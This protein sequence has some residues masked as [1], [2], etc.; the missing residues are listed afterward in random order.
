MVNSQ[1]D[2]ISVTVLFVVNL[3]NYVDRYTVAGV[4]TAVQT[5]Y[6]IS[7]SLG[8]LIQT[9]FLISFMV[10]SPICGYLGDRFNRKWIM[11]IGVGIWLGAVLG[12]SFVPANHFWLFL[13]L[14]SFVGIGEAS[15]SNVAPSL[16]SDMFNG[17]KRSTVFMIFYFAIPVGSGL[18]FIVGSNVATL[19][20][21]WQWGIRVSAIAGFIVMIALVLFTYE[22]ERGAADRANGDAKDTVVTTNTTYLE[23]LVILLKT[24][25]LVACTWGYT[26]LV[27]V[28]GTLSWWEPTVIQHLTAWHQGLNDTKELP[29]TDKDRVALYFGAITTAGGLIGVIFGSMLS[30]WLVTGWGPFKRFQTERAPPLVSGGGALLAAPLLLIGMIFG[31]KSLV[32]LYIMIFFGLTFLCFN[33]GLNIDMLTTVIHPNRRSTA[34]SYF[35]LVSHLFG[36]A[37]GPYLIG[38]ISDL[39]RHGSTLPKDQYHSLVTATYCCV[40]LLLISAGLYFV[41]SLT[42]VSDR[43]KFR[44][45][46]GLDDLQSKPIRTSTDSLERIGA[47]DE[48]MSSRL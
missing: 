19:T 3:L 38:L 14:R 2:Y 33:W 48:V 1:E 40:A 31:E 24:P 28:S 9:V 17:Q 41:S 44:M 30:K 25:T 5:Y 8:G 35:V 34:F 43:R 27:F 46:M 6:N 36:D 23:D 32:L 10:F 45:E 16:I 11:I 12:S 21:H 26:A 42:L 22:P 39:I 20:G 47:N 18:G 4:L 29:T 37:S 7:D 15:Y 13:V